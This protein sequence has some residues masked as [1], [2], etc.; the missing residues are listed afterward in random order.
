MHGIANLDN[1]LYNLQKEKTGYLGSNTRYS[2]MWQAYYI[3][4]FNI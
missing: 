3:F 2:T 1:K 4:G